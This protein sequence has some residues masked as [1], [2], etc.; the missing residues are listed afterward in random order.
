MGHSSN[1]FVRLF[2]VEI[3]E[4]RWG[5]VQVDTYQRSKKVTSCS[6]NG[7]DGLTAL[8]GGDVIKQPGF[9]FENGRL[10]Y[11]QRTEVRYRA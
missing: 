8:V 11:I 10:D 4:G 5:S 3:G 1:F 9:E 2:A 6:E 7:K